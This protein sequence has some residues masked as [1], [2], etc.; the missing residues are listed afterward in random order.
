MDR[1]GYFLA[2]APS[3]LRPGRLAPDN[4]REQYDS[5]AGKLRFAKTHERFQQELQQK[6]PVRYSSQNGLSTY[7]FV[8]FRTVLDDFLGR[9]ALSGRLLGGWAC[10]RVSFRAMAEG[11]F[12]NDPAAAGQFA[13][14]DPLLIDPVIHRRATHPGEFECAMQWHEVP[15]L[16]AL[17]AVEVAG[18]EHCHPRNKPQTVTSVCEELFF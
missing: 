9:C 17:L 5:G 15:F 7:R 2:D 10:I 18:I 1:N 6:R 16:L 13:P 3:G 8:H 11:L 4:D 12:A 14:V